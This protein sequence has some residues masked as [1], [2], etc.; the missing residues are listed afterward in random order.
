MPLLK[1]LL[2][3]TF[4]IDTKILNCFNVVLQVVPLRLCAQPLLQGLQRVKLRVHWCLTI[5]SHAQLMGQAL[6]V[7]LQVV[8]SSLL[9]PPQLHVYVLMVMGTQTLVDSM[10]L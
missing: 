10:Q 1:I 8:P 2:Q 9:V 5:K 6:C 3:P 4:C 7:H